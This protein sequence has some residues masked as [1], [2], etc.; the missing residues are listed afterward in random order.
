MEVGIL[1]TAALILMLSALVE[2]LI[3][4]FIGL[5]LEPLNQGDGNR[6]VFAQKL[7]VYQLLMRYSAAAISVA[8]CFAYSVDL[9][10]QVGLHGPAFVGYIATG[11]LIGR[12]SNYVHDFIS[13]WLTPPAP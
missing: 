8:L 9:M 10:G 13:R 4:Y 2:G 7:D 12:G 3:E 6:E 5:L 1:Q 11:L